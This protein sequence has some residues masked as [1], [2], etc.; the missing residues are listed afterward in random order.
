M[1]KNSKKSK[2]YKYVYLEHTV[3]GQQRWRVKTRGYNSTHKSE[4]DAAKAVDDFLIKI[5]KNAV[6]FTSKKLII[7]PVTVDFIKEAVETFSNCGDLSTVSRDRNLVELRYVAYVLAG[8]FCN[9]RTTFREIG[10]PFNRRH[11]TVIIGKNKFEFLKNQPSFAGSLNVYVKLSEQIR[12]IAKGKFGVEIMKS[13]TEIK[14]EYKLLEEELRLNY[15]KKVTELT[16]KLHNLGSRPVFQ[17]L[18]A[19]DDSLLDLFEIRAKAFLNMNK[20]KN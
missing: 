3:S 2:V 5:G 13:T 14:E 6:N 9:E 20:N 1:N 4:K 8:K 11:S 19:L 16:T 18:A 17:E 15:E 12:K 7:N 10:K